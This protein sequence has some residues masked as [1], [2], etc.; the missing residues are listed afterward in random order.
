MRALQP[1]FK[2]KPIRSY[3]IRSGRITPAQE[4]ALAEDWSFF[5][6][7]LHQGTAALAGAFPDTAND[8]VLEIGF[9]MGD[10]LLI[11]AEQHPEQNFVGIE[12]HVPGVGR[13]ISEA[14][15]RNLHNLRVFCADAIDVLNDCIIDDSL[16]RLQLFFP[17]PWHKSRHHKRRIVQPE[18]IDLVVQK[19]RTD[20]VLHMAT[21]WEPYAEVMLEVASAHSQLK[22]IA[23]DAQ[24]SARP[25]YRPATKFE[26][27]GE[28][29]GH[30]VHDLL[31]Q[32]TA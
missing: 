7:D 28:R 26:Q 24:Y 22:N 23:D 10:S 27:R 20:G 14:R 5:G 18:F 31:F 15:K 4:K 11:M 16:T 12:V 13:L 17:D 21:D 25:G 29:L 30:A 3:V 9:G 19:L 6:L 8:L 1:Q 2:K 32:K